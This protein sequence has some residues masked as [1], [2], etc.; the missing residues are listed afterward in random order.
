MTGNN[1]ILPVILQVCDL[2]G[3]FLTKPTVESSVTLKILPG[4]ITVILQGKNFC[5]S[6]FSTLNICK[7]NTSKVINL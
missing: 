5:G 2:T 4:N 7:N 3:T 1:V 6:S